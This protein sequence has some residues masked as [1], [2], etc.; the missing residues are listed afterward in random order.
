MPACQYSSNILN[1]LR[2][3][4]V[5]TYSVRHIQFGQKYDFNPQKLILVC[6]NRVFCIPKCY[7][8]IILKTLEKNRWF[9]CLV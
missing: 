6:L 9:M 7:F 2:R 8:K 3:S 4:K 5:N 1:I